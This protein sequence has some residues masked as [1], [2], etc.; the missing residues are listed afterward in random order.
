MPKEHAVIRFSDDGS[1]HMAVGSHSTG[2]G[3]ETSLCQI[4]AV[5]LGIDIDQIYFTQ[6]DTD[7]TPM[8]GGHGGSRGMEVGGNAVKQLANEVIMKGKD[9]ASHQFECALNDV[10]FEDGHFF[11]P[12]TNNNMSIGEIISASFDPSLFA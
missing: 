3:H 2:M 5:E 7:A 4:L 6:A 10:H 11:Q 12:N 9:I 1:V 8:G